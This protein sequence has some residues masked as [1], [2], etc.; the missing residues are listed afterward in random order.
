MLV[1]ETHGTPLGK[2]AACAFLCCSGCDVG[3]GSLYG[4]WGGCCYADVWCCYGDFAW[5]FAVGVDLVVVGVKDAYVAVDDGGCVCDVKAGDFPDGSEPSVMFM[6]SCF[7]PL[8]SGGL[9]SWP[10]FRKYTPP[11]MEPPLRPIVAIRRR[12]C[13]SLM[14][15]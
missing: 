10:M 6:A 15:R 7:A 12:V 3:D 9:Y 2:F 14:V 11:A 8:N 13:L 4:Y 1:S 5:A